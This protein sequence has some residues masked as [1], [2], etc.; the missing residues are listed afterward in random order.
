M[1]VIDKY[2][3]ASHPEPVKLLGLILRDFCLGHYSNMLRY[4]CAFAINESAI[5]IVESP[6]LGIPDL[7]LAILICS[8]TYEGFQEFIADEKAFAKETKQWGKAIKQMT[9]DKDFNLFKTFALF[10]Q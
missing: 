2:L 10:N 6:D 7:L 4:G 9:K 8:Q 3:K 5:P 1:A